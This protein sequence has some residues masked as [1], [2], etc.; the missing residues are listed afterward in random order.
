MLFRARDDKI[1]TMRSG[2]MNLGTDSRIGRFQAAALDARPIAFYG[3]VEFLRQLWIDI[4][5]FPR[6][7]FCIRAKLAAPGEIDRIM[8]AKARTLRHRI[9]QSFEGWPA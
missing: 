3:A 5:I 1:R 4:V 7:P 9:N 6:R 2:R 8:H